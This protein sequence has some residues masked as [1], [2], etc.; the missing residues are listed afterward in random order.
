[1]EIAN[2]R[3][4]IEKNGWKIESTIE[5]YFRYSLKKEKLILFTIKYPITL[6]LRLNVPFEVVS[7]KLSLA[8]QFWNLNQSTYR[9]IL[10]L[11]KSLRNLAIS[12]TLEQKFPLKGKENQLI[13]LLNLLIPDII[14]KENENTWLNRIRISLMNKRD[15]LKDFTQLNI[16]TIRESLKNVG[17]EPSFKIP[18]ELKYGIPKIRVPE[19]LIFSNN[20]NFD[21]FFILEKGYFSYFKDFSFNKFY[22]RTLFDSYSPYIL[23]ELFGEK[24]SEFRLEIFMENWIRFSRLILN[25]I[26]ELISNKKIDY[27]ELINFR[28]VKEFL[29][30][31]QNFIEEQN[32]LAFTALFYESSIAKKLFSIH[33]DLFNKPPSNFEVIE[34]LNQYTEA[35][36][37]IKNYRFEEA[38]RRLNESLKIYNKNQ[39]KKVVVSILLKLRKIAR[40]LNQNDL[41]LNYL[42][43]ALSVAK[44]GEIPIEFILKIHYKLG[45]SYFERKEL[46]EALEHFTIIKNFLE[47]EKVEIDKEGFLGM[48]Y[49][50]IGLIHLEENKIVES[51]NYF[52]KTIQIGND[53]PKVKLHYYLKRAIGFKNQGNYS[54]AQKFLRIGLN[55]VGLDFANKSYYKTLMDIV[56]ELSEYYIHY[57]KD[58]KKAMYLLKNAEDNLTLKEIGSIRRAIRWNLLMIDY[59]NTF[60]VNREKAQIYL[61][62]SQKLKKQLQ[63]IGVNE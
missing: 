55:T 61:K 32:N 63:T 15:K 62:Q 3:E 50:Y 40:I 37:L 49:L 12:L 39:Q 29:Y 28:P 4:F 59:Y 33:N 7:F 26:I 51:R 23:N 20:N 54:Q 58:G 8:F 1:M 38:T 13:D 46:I 10:Y 44:S 41:A 47:K 11:M 57:R 43:N 30:T 45:F 42:R 60:Q 21:D 52:K 36:D 24:S 27:S 48:T 35:E 18:W 56:L 31:N 2:L 14:H 53:I 6:P 16:S 17:L 22:V 19:T 34:S 5:N 25:S 9:I